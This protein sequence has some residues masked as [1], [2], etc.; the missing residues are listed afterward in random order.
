VSLNIG[1]RTFAPRLFMT[2]LTLAVFLGLVSLGRWQLH[3][4]AE[5]RVL[6]EA[7]AHGSGA[8][9]RID[10][11]S[12]PVPRYQEVQAQGRYDESR[13]ILIDNM[14]DAAGR[15][16]YYVVTPFLLQGGGAILVNRGF[17]PQG[18]SR[19]VLP[20]IRVDGHERQILGRIDHLPAAG[21]QLG[22]RPLLRPPYPVV[23]SF[24]SHAE[25][26]ALLNESDFSRA[27]E[28]ILLDQDQP[29]G[30]ER[31]WTPP[32]FPPERHLGYA[33]QWF[34]LAA[35]LLVIYVVTNTKKTERA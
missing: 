3:R 26:A 5:K 10:R 32:G 22:Q 14:V 23:A 12:P 20:P 25:L 11:A 4:A 7:F 33:V 9:E 13:Q 17:V 28:L 2:L 21:I 15:A 35:A 18:R 19:Q 6:F 30:Y 27:G 31:A 29:D 16:G 8:A 1:S 34:A 24:P